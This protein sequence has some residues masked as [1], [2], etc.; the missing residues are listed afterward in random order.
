MRITTHG[1]R[2]TKTEHGGRSPEHVANHG[3]GHVGHEY[4][5]YRTGRKR[6]CAAKP[7]QAG[8]H[9]W[10]ERE[11]TDPA[12]SQRTR[13]VSA[14]TRPILSPCQWQ[15]TILQCH[16]ASCPPAPQLGSD[17]MAPTSA[18]HKCGWLIKT[19][20]RRRQKK[21]SRCGV[22]GLAARI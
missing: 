13:Q 8:E 2:N 6:L 11:A 18:K 21:R 9:A 15:R 1:V 17:S 12:S 20:R 5:A 7:D 16:D 3:T 4:R 10:G 22:T 14:P 19:N